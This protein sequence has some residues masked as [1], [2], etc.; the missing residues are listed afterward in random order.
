[1]GGISRNELL[2]RGYQARRWARGERRAHGYGPLRTP[3]QHPLRAR[4]LDGDLIGVFRLVAQSPDQED[5]IAVFRLTERGFKEED[6][7]RRWVDFNPRSPKLHES[8]VLAVCVN[9]QLSQRMATI[10]HRAHAGTSLIWIEN[11][12]RNTVLE[13]QSI[14]LASVVTDD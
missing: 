7:K 6:K 4:S 2:P 8:P 1:M 12:K 5:L 3:Q 13:L 14:D 9:I 10:K 11:G